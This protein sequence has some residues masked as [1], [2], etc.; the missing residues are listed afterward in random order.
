MLFPKI[1]IP[2]F[3]ELQ[4][5]GIRGLAELRPR[6]GRLTGQAAAGVGSRERVRALLL[7]GSADQQLRGAQ[8]THS[9][10]R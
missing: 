6:A 8:G 3:S 2:L 10:L 7:S 9:S 1:I 4:E 5:L